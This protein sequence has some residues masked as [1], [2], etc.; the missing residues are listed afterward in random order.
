MT[1]PVPLERQEQAAI[2]K[3]LD[4]ALGSMG[5]CHVPNG[6]SR[7][8]VEAARLTGQG[9]KAGVPDLL[10][11]R[12]PPFRPEVRGVAIE[13]KRRRGGRVSDEQRAWLTELAAEGWLAMTAH[14]WDEARAFLESLGFKLGGHR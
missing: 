12:R 14:G 5:W 2:A 11:F 3:W 7:H 4:L 10:I 6:G 13:L 1:G 9:V 8:R